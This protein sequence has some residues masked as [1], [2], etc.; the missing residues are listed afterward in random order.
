MADNKEKDFTAQ[1]LALFN[2]DAPKK[3]KIDPD[4]IPPDPKEKMIDQAFSSENMSMRSELNQKQIYAVL[5]LQLFA[6]KYQ[7]SMVHD[8]TNNF[9]Q[10]QVSKGRQGRKEFKEMAQSIFYEQNQGFGMPPTGIGSR[11]L[12]KE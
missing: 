2:A 5:K 12:G 3:E 10:L 7:S 6:D 1:H 11:F 4:D 9:L 8:L